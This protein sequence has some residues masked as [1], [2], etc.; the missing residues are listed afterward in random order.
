MAGLFDKQAEIY[1]DARPTYPAHWYSMLASR[2]PLHSLAWDVG[3]G[4]GQ[5]ALGVAEHYD[6]VIATDVSAAQLKCAMQHPR[7]RY[8]HTPIPISNDEIVTLIG[9]ENSVDLITVAQAVHWF[10]VPNFYS[11]ATRLL[12]KPGGVLAVWCYNDVEVSPT[13]DPVMKRF[14][15]TT[16]PFWDPNIKHVFDG[17][18]KLPFP[19]KSVGLGCKSEPFPLDIPKQLAFEGFLRM[20]R[21]WSAVATAK[22]QGFDLL[23]EGVVRELE[24][25]WGGPDLVRCIVYKAFMLA[26]TV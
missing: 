20:L 11:L 17:Y 3:T 16:L 26:G 14:H 12:R 21:S 1:L 18:K 7:V 5:A 2:T 25:S 10:D 4:N 24:D 22:E 23:S 8:V 6:Q 9:G 15:D 13:F 19:F